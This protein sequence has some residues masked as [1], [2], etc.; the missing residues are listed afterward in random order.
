ML[1]LII[2]KQVADLR[3]PHFYQYFQLNERLK[4]MRGRT[5]MAVRDQITVPTPV[6]SVIVR[7]SRAALLETGL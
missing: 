3:F 6:V 1:S 2:V 5:L 4:L 7:L